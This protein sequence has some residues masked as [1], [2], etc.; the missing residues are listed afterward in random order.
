MHIFHTAELTDG[1]HTI[2]VMNTTIYAT[3]LSI[4]LDCFTKR[5]C[6][7]EYIKV[8]IR[9][10]IDDKLFQYLELT[11]LELE[12]HGDF[13]YNDNIV[14]QGSYT[15]VCTR[16]VFKLSNDDFVISFILCTND[17]LEYTKKLLTYLNRPIR[18]LDCFL[19]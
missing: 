6:N 12:P 8:I 2:K 7:I 15:C 5:Q 14:S 18:E 4:L 11:S 17:Q 10:I 16:N 13:I 3:S 19:S 1:K 9:S